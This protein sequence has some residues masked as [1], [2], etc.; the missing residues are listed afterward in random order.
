MRIFSSHMRPGQLEFAFGCNCDLLW[1]E[2]V[3]DVVVP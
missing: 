3:K 2:V 1:A